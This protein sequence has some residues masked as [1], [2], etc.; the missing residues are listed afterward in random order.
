M[1]V[2]DMLESHVHVHN[3]LECMRVLNACCA[4]YMFVLLAEAYQT[5]NLE[6]KHQTGVN[7]SIM[8]NLY[9]RSHTWMYTL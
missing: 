4:L 2:I 6:F 1:T 8:H 9:S 3:L 7:V 5:C